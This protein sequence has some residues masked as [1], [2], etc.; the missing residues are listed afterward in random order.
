MA[1]LPA[2][3]AY[4]DL[5]RLAVSI[6]KSGLFGI[7]TPDQA[8]AL[9]MIAQ[10]E[11]RHPA[12]AARDYDVIQGR[13][14]KKAE[15]M[16]RDFLDAG[17]K[18]EWHALDDTTADATFSHPQGGIARIVW[19]MPRATQAGLGGKD[20]W[21][22]FPRQMLRSRTVSEGVRTVWPMATS[23]MYEPGEVGDMPTPQETSHTGVTIDATADQYMTA[24]RKM[25]ENWE[26]GE[27]RRQKELVEGATA[28]PGGFAPL[29][30][31][32]GVSLPAPPQQG[33]APRTMKE[34]LDAFELAANDLTD[35]TA[36]DKLITAPQSLWMKDHATGNAKRRYDAIITGVMLKWFATGS[37]PGDGDP[38]PPDDVPTDPPT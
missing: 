33:R 20:M 25:M 29:N 37:P 15:A 2:P 36:A 5:E 32:G 18:I 38:A 14:S 23:G 8:L 24:Q 11:G 26:R 22:K 34:W 19:D 1:Q 35:A 7:K 3:L 13:P 21:K 31:D 6:A 16:A 17:G 4:S 28:S 10:A 27:A 9:M 12:L 30:P